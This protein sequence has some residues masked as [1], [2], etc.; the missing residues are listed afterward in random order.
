[1]PASSAFA[2]LPSPTIAPNSSVVTPMTPTTLLRNPP[3]GLSQPSRPH[4]PLLHHNARHRHSAATNTQRRRRR[5][6]LTHWLEHPILLTTLTRFPAYS[7][8]NLAGLV[9]AKSVKLLSTY[10]STPAATR[11]AWW[12]ELRDEVR[13]HAKHLRC[14][15]VLGYSESTAIHDDLVVL[16]ATGTAANLDPTNTKAAGVCRLTHVPYPARST[17]LHAALA[18]CAACGRRPVPPLVLA[19]VDPP[20]DLPASVGPGVLIEAHVLR[21]KKKKDG[22]TNAALVSDAIPFAEFDLHRQLT[23][24]LRAVG[25]N[26]VFGLKVQLVLGDEHLV[27]VATGTAFRLPWIPGP[28]PVV[29]GG[30]GSGSGLMREG[31]G[32]N[33]SNGNKAGG[34]DA[35]SSSDSDSDSSTSSVSVTGLGLGLAGVPDSSYTPSV[36]HN[37]AADDPL[38]NSSDALN[39]NAMA[40]PAMLGSVTYNCAPPALHIPA[41][42]PMFAHQ[43]VV[44]VRQALLSA[45]SPT[46][47]PGDASSKPDARPSSSFASATNRRSLSGAAASAAAAAF[48]VPPPPPNPNALGDMVA[49]NPSASD[50]FG[51]LGTAMG[52]GGA[53]A[54]GPDRLAAIMNALYMQT[55]LQFAMLRPCLLAGVSHDVSILDG[56][57]L[58]V[59]MVGTVMGRVDVP[60]ELSALLG[61]ADADAGQASILPSSAAAAGFGLGAGLGFGGTSGVEITPLA[62]IPHTRITTYLGRLALHFVKEIAEHHHQSYVSHHVVSHPVPLAYAC[63]PNSAP[64]AWDP[65]LAGSVGADDVDAGGM[66]AFVQTTWTEIMAVVGAHVQ[67]LGGNALMA[68]RVEHS[69]FHDGLKNQMYA[70]VCVSGDVCSVVPTAGWRRAGRVRLW[71]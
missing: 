20:L 68:F 1:D 55:S 2:P 58:Q 71:A 69:G 38:N 48:P 34:G 60:G 15:H 65:L 18:T 43:I 16:S 31:H 19:T 32:T 47:V 14:T 6:S 9:T 46:G 57:V 45:P 53:A 24:K 56:G 3:P 30:L 67:A 27:A 49:S 17:T 4:V 62:S 12:G 28:E 51:P 23:G 41:P 13:A 11:D 44:A 52:N 35:S 10:D 25:G 40:D 37:N 59:R 54:S 22:E 8:V 66:G 42:G 39:T 70:L 5:R 61:D 64:N 29:A 21:P 36:L 33:N 63:P 26:A 50:L 7:I